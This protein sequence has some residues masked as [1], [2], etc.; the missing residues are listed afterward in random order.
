MSCRI[1]QQM[2]TGMHSSKQQRCQWHLL[3]FFFS[4]YKM[5]AESSRCSGS[6]GKGAWGSEE[7]LM[8]FQCVNSWQTEHI[9]KKQGRNC[10]HTHTHTHKEKEKKR[11]FVTKEFSG[12]LENTCLFLFIPAW[13]PQLMRCFLFLESFLPVCGDPH[14]LAQSSSEKP[15]CPVKLC[16]CHE[17]KKD[18]L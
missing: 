14:L 16:C 4:I 2:Q 15:C 5:I 18:F 13:F 8:Q 12:H 10:T 17:C 1:T 6:R 3:L 7:R 11:E 9:T